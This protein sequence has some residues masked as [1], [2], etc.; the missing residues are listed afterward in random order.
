MSAYGLVLQHGEWGPPGLLAEWAD[1]RGIALQVHRS[2][3]GE[4]LPAL[5]G[6][7]FVASLGSPHGPDDVHVPA[8]AA[9]RELIAEAIAR[10]TPVLGLCFGGQMLAAALGATTEPVAEPELGWYQVTTSAPELIAAGPWL[11]WHYLRFTLPPGARRLAESAA[12]LQAF[13][14]GR[15]L[16]VQFHPESTIEI[17]RGWA[18]LDGDRLRAAGIEDG[19]ERLERGR[20]HA[21][22]AAAAAFRLFDGFWQRAQQ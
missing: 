21:A 13:T 17:V 5:N 20:G 16:G 9:E 18:R 11:Q 7:A 1:A 14:H 22:R 8:V 6:H 12:G 15:H 19:E 4:P 3:L 2:D 10:D